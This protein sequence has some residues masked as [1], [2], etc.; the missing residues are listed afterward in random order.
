M[1]VKKIV[2]DKKEILREVK[3]HNT[4]PPHLHIIRLLGVTHSDD[5][6][7][8]NICMELADKSLIHVPA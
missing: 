1:A 8:I 4:L 7:I 5:G 6:F 2:C 3:V